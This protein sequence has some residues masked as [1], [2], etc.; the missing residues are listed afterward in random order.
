MVN[1]IGGRKV[2][3]G[4]LFLSVGVTLALVLGDLPSN[5]M[6]FMIFLS[7]GFF[8]GN[9]IE[10]T[11]TAVKDRPIKQLESIKEEL[12]LTRQQAQVNAESVQVVQQAIQQIIGKARQ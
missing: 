5:L 7:A 11:A 2:L 3:F 4:L 9:G 6:E 1:K 12:A 8:L 10:H